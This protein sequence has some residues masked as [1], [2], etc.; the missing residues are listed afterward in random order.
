MVNILTNKHTSNLLLI[1]YNNA[2]SKKRFIKNKYKK[3]KNIDNIINKLKTRKVYKCCRD[4][5]IR[6]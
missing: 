4:W 6:G 1:I 3:N 5:N 2:S